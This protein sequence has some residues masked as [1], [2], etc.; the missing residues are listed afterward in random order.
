[1]LQSRVTKSV[2]GAA[3]MV[4]AV[5]GGGAPAQAAVYT[6]EWDPAYGAAFPSLGWKGSASFFIP[7]ACLAGAG[8]IENVNACS[9]GGMKV[10]GAAVT[11][12]NLASPSA[13]VETLTFDPNGT[14]YKMFVSAGT[15]GGVSTD[16]LGPAHATSSIAGEGAY[17]FDLKFLEA[18][19]ANVKLYH[20]VGSTDPICA[21]TGSPLG[22]GF[23]STSPTITLRLVPAVPE[24]QTYALLLAG[25]A[26]IGFVA[27]RRRR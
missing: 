20:T 12:Y 27:R 19:T 16:F 10:L 1:M 14:V 25:L 24:P 3:I 4:A 26:V 18:L 23:S 22:C 21:F 11:F 7:D 9:G 17:Y 5:L 6:G 8:W 15:L 13:A 2:L